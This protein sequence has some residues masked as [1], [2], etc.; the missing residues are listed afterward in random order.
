[1]KLKPSSKLTLKFSGYFVVFYLLFVMSIFFSFGLFIYF[2]YDKV[3]DNV[4]MKT[5]Y[6]FEGIVENEQLPKSLEKAAEENLGQFYLLD[7]DLTILD[8]TGDVCQICDLTNEQLLNL[9]LQGMQKWVA[10]GYTFLFIADLPADEI[11]QKLLAIWQPSKPLTAEAKAILKEA[12]AMVDVYDKKWQRTLTWGASKKALTR[13]DLLDENYDIFELKELTQSKQ[14]GD[15]TVAVRLDNPSYKPFYGPF[16]KAMILLVSVF[17]GGH[18]LLIIGVLLFSLSISRQFIRPI[19][20]I[21]SRIERLAQFKYEPLKDKIIYHKKTG[22]MKRKY[23][24]F[25]PVDTSLNHLSERLAYNERQLQHTEQLREEWIT[26][27]SHDLKTPLSSIYGYSTM[28]ASEDYHWSKEEI[29]QFAKTMQEKASYMDALIKDLTYTYQLKNNAVHLNKERILLSDWLEQ[30]QDTRIDITVEH[31]CD[32]Y[33]D[34]LAL[35]RIMDN[36][37]SNAIKYTPED[38]AIQLSATCT[39][40]STTITISDKGPGIPQ[41]KLD[42]LFTRYYRETNTTDAAEGTGLGLAIT[43]QLIDLHGGTIDVQS[44]ANGTTFTIQLSNQP[45]E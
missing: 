39:N 18:I 45:N 27:L 25:E 32:V 34:K 12:G 10:D 35:K 26:G 11:L 21:M 22:K 14:V 28:L 44:N 9:E 15:Y 2:I 24:L 42:N 7:Q 23:R 37:L 4:H 19:V 43:K 16:N 41:A 38:Q 20:Y 40:R 13:A 3:G 33:A 8:Y 17:I 6:E 36:L 30:F 29:Q 5:T 1:M 31:G